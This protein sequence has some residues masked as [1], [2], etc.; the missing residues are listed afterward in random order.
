MIQHKTQFTLNK[1]KSDTRTYLICADKF[2]SGD[3]KYRRT[4]Q[5]T[6]PSAES[7]ARTAKK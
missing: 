7:S 6:T 5:F 4:S 1:N 2:G 3:R